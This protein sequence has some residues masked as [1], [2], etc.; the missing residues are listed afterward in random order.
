MADGNVYQG[1]IHSYDND[2]MYLIMQMQNRNTQSDRVFP[3]FG[4][5]GGHGFW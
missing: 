5:F 3:G 4:G 1:K 2:N